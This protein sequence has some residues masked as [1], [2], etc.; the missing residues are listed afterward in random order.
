MTYAANFSAPSEG[1]ILGINGTRGRL[2]T[3]RYTEPARC[4]F[5]VSAPQT[6]SYFPLFG[7]RQVIEP[8]QVEGSHG[9]ADPLL[10]R[11]LFEGP[12]HESEELQQMAGARDGAYAVAVGEAVW[13]SVAENRPITIAE[14]LP[15]DSS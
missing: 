6:I 15:L 5:P 14:L 3:T 4:P 9:G 2:E 12:S 13:R 7:E 8:P 11:D 10:R 1:Y